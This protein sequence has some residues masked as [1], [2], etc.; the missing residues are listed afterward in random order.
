MGKCFFLVWH[1]MPEIFKPLARFC[2][3]TVSKNNRIVFVV[4]TKKKKINITHSSVSS[5]QTGFFYAKCFQHLFTC[6]TFTLN[7]NT[8]IYI[9]WISQGSSE[10][11]SV[12]PLFPSSANAPTRSSRYSICWNNRKFIL[13]LHH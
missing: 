8:L 12:L 10:C 4:M 2:F 5:L 6:T 1:R 11:M 13:H 9:F 7:E 3:F